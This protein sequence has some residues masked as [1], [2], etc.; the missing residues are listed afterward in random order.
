[1]TKKIVS[2]N[3]IKFIMKP[4]KNLGKLTSLKYDSN[5]I[6]SGGFASLDDSQMNKIK[7]GKAPDC[8]NSACANASCPGESNGVCSNG[9]C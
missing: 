8:T 2:Y 5:G 7:G 1:M 6:L 4:S 3:K 9:S